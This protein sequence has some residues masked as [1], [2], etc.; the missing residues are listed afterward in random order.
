MKKE[1]QKRSKIWLMP[2]NEFK[3][4]VKNSKSLKEILQ[5]FSF[6]TSHG[7]YGTLKRRLDKEDI[8]YS[9]IPL[10][11]SHNKGKK[12]PGKAI[13]LEKVMIKNSTYTRGTLKK[14]LLRNGILE[15]KC[16]ECGQEGEWKNKKL[17]MVL[18]HINGIRDDHRLGNLRMLCPNC[19]SQQ[20]TFSGRKRY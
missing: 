7:N 17:V 1:R 18:D 13:A 2:L 20:K 6:V 3:Q 10:G 14:R 19:N 4:L 15:N 8:D 5:H 16:S 9:H 12:F 11:R